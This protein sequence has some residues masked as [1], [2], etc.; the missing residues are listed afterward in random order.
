MLDWE[1]RMQIALRA[2][3]GLAYLHEDSNPRVIDQDFKLAMC[4]KKMT[5]FPKFLILAWQEKQLKATLIIFQH[6]RW[7]LLG[8]WPSAPNGPY[9][10]GYY[11]VR[12]QNPSDY[13]SPSAQFPCAPGKQYYGRGS[14]PN[15]M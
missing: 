11:I 6:R 13:C 14:H 7:E 12:E 1:A 5:L 10:W 2:A 4:Y 15:L 8:G 9:A 3:R